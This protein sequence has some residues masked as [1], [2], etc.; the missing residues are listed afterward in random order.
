MEQICQWLE[1]W[2]CPLW[3]H[4]EL[5][6]W[7]NLFL[8]VEQAKHVQLTFVISDSDEF[9]EG[10]ETH[11]C[12]KAANSKTSYIWWTKKTDVIYISRW[13]WCPDSERF[14]EQPTS[15]SNRPT[16]SKHVT[17]NRPSKVIT[18][19]SSQCQ[20]NPAGAQT[21]Y[22][23]LHK[24]TKC[25]CN[26]TT[27]KYFWF[28]F[29]KPLILQRFQSHSLRKKKHKNQVNNLVTA[30]V[31]YSPKRL[32]WVLEYCLAAAFYLQPNCWGFNLRHGNCVKRL[33]W[34]Y[35]VFWR[36][37]KPQFMNNSGGDVGSSN[38]LLLL[39]E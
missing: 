38:K 9:T 22:T 20:H 23:T 2:Q 3:H 18:Y 5:L 24:E 8:I 13:L 17:L 28:S 14:S 30:S 11:H 6:L 33:Y 36:A 26:N 7:A 34:T 4:K 19:S 12:E 37:V 35:C 15:I 21:F 31:T 25:V 29:D 1:R 27:G 16:L 39:S 10:M 32:F